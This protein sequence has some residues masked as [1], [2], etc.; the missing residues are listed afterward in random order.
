[1][2]VERRVTVEGK[3]AA[4]VRQ[5][6]SRLPYG[7]A[8]AASPSRFFCLSGRSFQFAHTPFIAQGFT[9]RRRD[10]GSAASNGNTLAHVLLGIERGGNWDGDKLT[11]LVEHSPAKA[12]HISL[13]VVFEGI[14][15]S[16]GKTTW[17]YPEASKASYFQQLAAWRY[18][19]STVEQIVVDGTAS[20]PAE[21]VDAA[22]GD[23]PTAE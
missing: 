14:E 6:T 17:R 9:T 4:Q 23:D 15:D 7:A 19:L 8:S 11:A 13:A 18:G 10:V 21:A 1:M 22:D 3:P 12:Q 2:V 20:R 16:T 5:P